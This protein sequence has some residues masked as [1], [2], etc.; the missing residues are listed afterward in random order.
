MYVTALTYVRTNERENV[1]NST[2]LCTHKCSYQD[3]YH[4][5]HVLQRGSDAEVLFAGCLEAGLP[6]GMCSVRWRDRSE[7]HGEFGVCAERD[8]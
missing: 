4:G 5:Y 7:Y 6:E 3:K 8:I 2:N 1:C